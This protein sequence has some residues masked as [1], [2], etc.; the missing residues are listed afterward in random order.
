MFCAWQ[1]PLFGWKKGKR[2]KA[3]IFGA[4]VL[5]ILG[6]EKNG[7]CSIGPCKHNG[8]G[9]TLTAQNYRQFT[10]PFCRKRS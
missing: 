10:I 2:R 7:E 4:K 5:N 6:Q 3:I 8:D 9:S 1:V